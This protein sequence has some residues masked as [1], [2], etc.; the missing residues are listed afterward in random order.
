M[1]VTPDLLLHAYAAGL[2]P[3]AE[4]AD[5]A[6]LHWFDPAMRGILPLDGFHVP[7]RLRRTLRQAP[8]EIRAD[9]AFRQVIEACAEPAPDR[10]S[11]WINTQILDLYEALHRR[12]RAHSVECWLIDPAGD[13]QLVGGLY[14]VALGGA[15]FGESMFSRV[16]DASKVAL[17][18]LAGLLIEGG[19]VLLDT[20]FTTEHLARFGGIEIPRRVYKSRLESALARDAQFRAE[21]A[22]EAVITVLD[23]RATAAARDRA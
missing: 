8:F 11:T 20:Q 19:F 16:T 6:D 13:R 12:G 17:C 21:R 9:T 22:R 3:M 4:S 23:R 7:R 18:H 1:Q 2:F 5:A 14:G 10:P 15:F